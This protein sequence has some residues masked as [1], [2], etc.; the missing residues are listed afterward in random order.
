M[1]DAAEE[2]ECAHGEPDQQVYCTPG[3]AETPWLSSLCQS[4][5]PHQT[6]G[7]CEEQILRNKLRNFLN[8]VF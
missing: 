2:D 8:M 7:Q 6:T 3:D 4:R 5:L 1:K